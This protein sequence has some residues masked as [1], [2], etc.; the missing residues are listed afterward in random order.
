MSI[1]LQGFK[2]P[3][4]RHPPRLHFRVRGRIIPY[5]DTPRRNRIDKYTPAETAIAAAVQAVEEAGADTLLTEAVTLLIQAQAKVADYVDA[6]QPQ[7]PE[8]AQ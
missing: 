2:S 1:R 3:T 5:M 4:T 6:H 8:N 7:P